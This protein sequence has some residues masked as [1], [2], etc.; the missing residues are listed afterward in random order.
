MDAAQIAALAGEAK[1]LPSVNIRPVSNKTELHVD[2]DYLAYYFA[3]NDDTSFGAARRNCV[4]ALLNVATLVGAGGRRVVHLSAAG[5][6]KGKRYRI[7]TVKPYQGQRDGGRRP[8]NWE[9]MRSWLEAGDLP[10]GWSRAIWAD[11]EADDGVAAL[12]RY[13]LDRNG[14]PAIFTRDKDFR[15]IPGLHVDF[16]SLEQTMV[17]R[18]TWELV[19][20][21]GLVYGRKWFWLQLLQGDT[22]DNIP[23]LPKLFGKQCG[24]KTA[25]AHLAG[26]DEGQTWTAVTEAYREHYG[27]EWADRLV[28]QAALLWLRTDLRADVSN[29]QIPLG[30]GSPV[31][32]EAIARM[33]ERID[34]T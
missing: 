22:A 12:A 32:N 6:D 23:G 8:K 17:P 30:F 9:A 2:G 15:M 7:A 28:E 3:G 31:I 10:P 16:I 4:D 34:P 29:I 18:G 5:G 1:P 33:K 14:L 21:E 26:L 20:N 24:P 13:C 25:E 27:D 19:A 11:R